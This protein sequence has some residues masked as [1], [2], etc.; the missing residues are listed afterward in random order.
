MILDL[1]A[2]SLQCH[3][4]N[5]CLH[6]KYKLLSNCLVKV[7][8]YIYIF[9]PTL[10]AKL[11]YLKYK[12][13]EHELTNKFT[14]RLYVLKLLTHTANVQPEHLQFINVNLKE[15]FWCVR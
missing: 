15:A 6:I 4:H 13:F 14:Y 5:V 3:C 7:F 9:I 11:R 10:T 1:V 8:S 12:I 2:L